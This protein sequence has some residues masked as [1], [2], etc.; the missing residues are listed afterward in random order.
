MTR[1]KSFRP[2]A[3][4]AVLALAASLA[5]CAPA[6]NRGGAS[7]MAVT[8]GSAIVPPNGIAENNSDDAQATGGI[9]VTSQAPA[10][11]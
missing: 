7:R 4:A 3:L 10:A 1:T 6:A 9:P 11:R 5:A 8:R 2:L